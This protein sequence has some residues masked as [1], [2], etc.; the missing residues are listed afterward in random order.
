MGFSSFVLLLMNIGHNIH[1]K[2]LTNNNNNNNNNTNDNKNTNNNNNY[3]NKFARNTFE[4][5]II[6]TA[7]EN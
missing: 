2:L 7:K 6:Y 5:Q 1:F 4:L 3:N